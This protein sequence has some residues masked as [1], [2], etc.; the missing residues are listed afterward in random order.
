MLTL[1]T[2]YLI[3]IVDIYLIYTTYYLN[4]YI[5]YIYI[6]INVMFLYKRKSNMFLV[7]LWKKVSENV[8]FIHVKICAKIKYLFI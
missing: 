8:F 2:C 4:T 5:I 6:Y 3:Q 7:S 1:K